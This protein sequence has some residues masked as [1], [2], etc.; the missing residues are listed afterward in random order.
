MD[1]LD[2]PLLRGSLRLGNPDLRIV[3]A[4]GFRPVL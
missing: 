4:R 1:H 2:S 3:A